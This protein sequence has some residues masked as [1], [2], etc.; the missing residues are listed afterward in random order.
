MSPDDVHQ[1]PASA[2]THLVQ[3]PLVAG[4]QPETPVTAQHRQFKPSVRGYYRIIIDPEPNYRYEKQWKNGKFKDKSLPTVIEEISQEI[5]YVAGKYEKVR[6]ELNRFFSGKDE[7]KE[8]VILK[9]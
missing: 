4:G 1:V 6:L 2:L 5:S 7:V 3:S 9:S 8:A